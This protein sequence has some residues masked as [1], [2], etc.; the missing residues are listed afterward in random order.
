VVLALLALVAVAGGAYLAARAPAPSPVPPK[1]Q[2]P[3]E[4]VDL[5]EYTR[6]LLIDAATL[7]RETFSVRVVLVLNPGAGDLTTL[8]LEVERRAKLLRD[9]VWTDVFGPRSDAELRKAGA[10]EAL[11]EA[12][13]RRV[14]RELGPGRGG[15]D[16]VSRVLFPDR[17]LPPRR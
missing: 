9:A 7:Q 14:N 17:S 13:R 8:R 10:V 5:G 2:E 3:F 15:Q 4:E 1:V 6:E 12:L 16:I 11:R